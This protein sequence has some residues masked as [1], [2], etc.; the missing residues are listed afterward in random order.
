MNENHS[1][2][3][4][5]EGG[6]GKPSMTTQKRATESVGAKRGLRRAPNHVQRGSWTGPRTGRNEGNLNKV[7]TSVHQY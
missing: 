3:G 6:M 1:D 4:V 2:N 5:M 7:R